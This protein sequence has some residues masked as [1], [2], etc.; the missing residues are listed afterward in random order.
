M[1][2]LNELKAIWLNV[3]TTSLLSSNEMVTI[4]KNNKNTTLRRLIFLVL[5][6]F[7][8]IVLVIFASAVYNFKFISSKIGEALIVFSGLI[9]M[10]TNLNSLNRFYKLKVCSNKQYISF[11]EKTQVRQLF[12]F[13]YTQVAGLA[14][15]FIGLVFYLYELVYQNQLI[16][17][18]SYLLLLLYFSVV[19]FYL[20]P[21][22]YKKGIVKLNLELEKVR[23]ISQQF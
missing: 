2:N 22:S 13:K 5:G 10:T 16:M 15:S 12:Y 18:I 3:K 9:L 20:R 14:F 6:A 1:D 19:F 8:M 23:R 21:K 11:L 4:I 7:A 17:L